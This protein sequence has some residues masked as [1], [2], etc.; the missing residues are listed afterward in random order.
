MDV[1]DFATPVVSVE[2]FAQGPN[3]RL[4]IEPKGLWEHS[5]YQTD[6]R[7]IVEIKPVQE[8]PTA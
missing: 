4:I 1:Q 6:N 5:A 8:D 7:F 2:T 3:A